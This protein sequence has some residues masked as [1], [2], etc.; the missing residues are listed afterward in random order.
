MKVTNASDANNLLNDGRIFIS[1]LTVSFFLPF[2][3]LS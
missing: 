3:L 1:K 2:F